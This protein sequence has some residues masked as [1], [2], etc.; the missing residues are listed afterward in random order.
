MLFHVLIGGLSLTLPAGNHEFLC[1]FSDYGIRV[2]RDQPVRKF[3]HKCLHDG[4][5]RSFHQWCFWQLPLE[6]LTSGRYLEV[7]LVLSILRI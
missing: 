3:C 7:S 1:D 6:A 5:I 2:G 4:G